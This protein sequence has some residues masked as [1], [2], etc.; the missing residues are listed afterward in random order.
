MVERLA[1]FTDSATFDPGGDFEAFLKAVPGR[2][3][4]YLFADQEERPIQLLCVKNLR[5]SLKRRLSGEE[6]MG[7]SKRVDYRQV[8]RKIYWRRVDSRFEADWIYYE[9]ARAIFPQTYRGLV[10]FREAW[11]V[12]VDPGARFP[13]YTR[14]SEIEGSGARGQGSEERG[15]GSGVYLGPIAT[16]EAAGKLIEMV[17]DAFDLCRYYNILVQSPQGKACAY[18]Q[19]HRCAAPCDG[20]VSMDAFR[21]LYDLSVRTLMDPREMIAEQKERMEEAGRELK[22]ELAGK[23]KGF[24]DLLEKMHKGPYRQMRTMEEFHFLSLQPGPWKGTVKVF[25]ISPGGIEE[26]VGLIGEPHDLALTPALSR[27]TGRGS[28]SM[29]PRSTGGRDKEGATELIGLVSHHLYQA[30]QSGLFLPIREMSEKSIL[31]AYRAVLRQKAPETSEDEGIV[32][33]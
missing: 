33:E 22:F 7:V 16:K 3:A 13:R 23:I 15:Q 30:K 17:E 32:H 27:S 14:T 9:A 5:A 24:I 21:T 29:I 25:L 4:V 12:Q 6:M 20:S 26:L 28:N 1:I 18:K 2:W 31:Q 11:F 10:G 8:V 19:M